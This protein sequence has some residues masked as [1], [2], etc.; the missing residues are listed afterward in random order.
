MVL[1]ART[2]AYVYLGITTA[3]WGVAAVVIKTTLNYLPPVTFLFFRYVLNLIFFLPIFLVWKQ[4]NHI[5]LHRVI[6]LL[7]L[8]S[9]LSASL[10]L[11]FFGFQQTSAIEGTF[12]SSLSPIFVVVS[13]AL[14][15]KEKITRQEKIG[16]FITL[17]GALSI[18]LLPY[19][20]T[21]VNPLQH[22]GGNLMTL[23]YSVIYSVYFIISKY[24]LN[25]KHHPMEIV[26]FTIIGGLIIFWPLSVWEQYLINA[27]LYH[28]S[29]LPG[30]AFIGLYHLGAILNKLPLGAWFGL[31]YMSIFSTILANWTNI[32]GLE[33][34]EASEATIFTYLQP[35]VTFPVAFI[36][37]GESLPAFFL[38][39]ALITALGVYITEKR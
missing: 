36:I 10:L 28:I 21:T 16:F 9:L 8:G 34:I 26:F 23:A 29:F 31:F 33:L 14:F 1:S 32:K 30:K 20:D 4:K 7:A 19:L 17:V 13:G 27:P 5:K 18:T 24:L 11:I 35:V 39:G 25:H 15:L 3:I 2:K 12:L 38:A 22:L 37:L 6:T